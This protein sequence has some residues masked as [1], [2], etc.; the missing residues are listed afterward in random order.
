VD[1]TASVHAVDDDNNWVHGRFDYTPTTV[2]AVGL[3]VVADNDDWPL[4]ALTVI[5]M[6]ATV[7]SRDVLKTENGNLNDITDDYFENLC[8]FAGN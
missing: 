8:F 6:L 5:D 2:A 7:N 1:W 3:I 4:I